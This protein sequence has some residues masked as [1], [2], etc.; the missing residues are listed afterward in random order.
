MRP[1]TWDIIIASVFLILLL[2]CLL[3]RRHKALSAL[4][5]VYIAYIV[6]VNWG[7]KTAGLFTGERVL[8]GFVWLKS[9]VP[10]YIVQASLFLL[11]AVLIMTLVKFSGKRSHYSTLEVSVYVT[12]AVALGTVFLVAFLPSDIRAKVFSS[13]K[14]V[15]IIYKCRDYIV[16]IPVIAMMFFGVYNSDDQ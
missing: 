14:I 4:V 11:I 3:I 1:I 9:A 16:L 6:T 8:F 10:S 15:P 12:L 13:S 7:D 5:S 2:F